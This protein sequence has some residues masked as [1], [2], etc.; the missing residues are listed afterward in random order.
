MKLKDGFE[1]ISSSL[2]MKNL[3]IYL[4]AVE[5]AKLF[6]GMCLDLKQPCVSLQKLA[7]TASLI[8]PK[9][10]DSNTRVKKKSV[11]AVLALWKKSTL[12]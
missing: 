4:I 3:S 6:Y 5:A 9:A 11:E 7:F 12:K 10:A 2:E 1:I 8:I